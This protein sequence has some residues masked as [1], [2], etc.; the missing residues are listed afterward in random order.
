MV[1]SSFYWMSWAAKTTLGKSEYHWKQDRF[2]NRWRRSKCFKT[3]GAGRWLKMT[4]CKDVTRT[5]PSSADK[6][7]RLWEEKQE[8]EQPEPLRW[9]RAQLR[10][11]PFSNCPFS[12]QVLPS[13]G[14]MKAY[15]SLTIRNI[16]IFTGALL[17]TTAM[18]S[19]CHAGLESSSEMG[20]NW[21]EVITFQ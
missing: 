9:W 16:R 7:S 20:T 12:F 5:W 1:L 21:N 17:L 2:P 15:P 4:P 3:S 10:L 11:S 14:W 18:R 19:F 6:Q 8:G 13:D